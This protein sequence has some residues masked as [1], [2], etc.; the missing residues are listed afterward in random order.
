MFVEPLFPQSRHSRLERESSRS[1][2]REE[3]LVFVTEVGMDARFR[4]HDGLRGVQMNLWDE[5][6]FVG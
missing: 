6:E 2:E 5:N 1:R 4:G 3:A